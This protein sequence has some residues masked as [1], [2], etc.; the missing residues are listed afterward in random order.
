MPTTL[1]KD[2][3]AFA[4]Y[5]G[6]GGLVVVPWRRFGLHRLYVNSDE[7][8]LVGWFD[9]LSNELVMEDLDLLRECRTALESYGNQHAIAALSGQC[10]PPPCESLSPPWCVPEVNGGDRTAVPG[11][12]AMPTDSHWVDLASNSPGQGIRRLAVQSWEEDP[13]GVLTAE[14]NGVYTDERSWRIGADGEEAVGV[15]LA[16]L[17]SGWRV[18]HSIPVHRGSSDIDHLAIGPSGVFT[19]NAKHHPGG[20]VWI[21]GDNARVNGQRTL[22]VRKSRSEAA[23]TSRILSAACGFD[24]PTMGV[25]AVVGAEGGV[26]IKEQPAEGTV[27][28]LD[29]EDLSSW[30]IAQ[31]TALQPHHAEV[32]FWWARRSTTWT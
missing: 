30:L 21:A 18:L 32:L 14:L 5:Q 29:H 2:R 16:R 8:Q 13:F 15:E 19:I 12:A 27:F 24:V 17:P 3:A 20:N 1:L 22:Y 6:V 11:S 25:I 9:L 4:D 10:G 26:R 31:P 23:R 7:G 28:V